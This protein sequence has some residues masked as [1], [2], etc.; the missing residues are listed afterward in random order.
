[1]TAFVYFSN[2]RNFL[3]Q[4][5]SHLFVIGFLGVGNYSAGL[6]G[7]KLSMKENATMATQ[8]SKYPILVVTHTIS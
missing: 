8:V 7:S 5:C 6:G 1:M 2:S 3:T 4:A